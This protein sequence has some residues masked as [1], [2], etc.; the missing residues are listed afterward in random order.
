MIFKRKISYGGNMSL[1]E[2]ISVGNRCDGNISG[3]ILSS[4]KY[5]VGNSRGG[6][7][8]FEKLSVGKLLSG[9]SLSLKLSCGKLSLGKCSVGS[10]RGGKLSCGKLSWIRLLCFGH[11]SHPPD[12]IRTLLATVKSLNIC[13]DFCATEAYSR[14]E[15]FSI[16]LLPCLFAPRLLDVQGF[17]D[18]PYY[19]DPPLFI[20][21]CR[22]H[23]LCLCLKWFNL[24]IAYL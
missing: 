17:S 2:I 19:L 10:C 3:G 20:R 8:F 23:W 14:E 6:K 18:P 5:R 4:V 13:C 12:L 21:H 22:V 24:L 16:Y 9:K 7:L 15:N 11:F 1:W